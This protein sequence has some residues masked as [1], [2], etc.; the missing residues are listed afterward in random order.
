MLPCPNLEFLEF[1]G[2]ATG[3]PPSFVSELVKLRTFRFTECS[4]LVS[5]R[6]GRLIDFAALHTLP[7][8]AHVQFYHSACED[9]LPIGDAQSQPSCRQ[10]SIGSRT[11]TLCSA[12]TNRNAD[13]DPLGIRRSPPLEQ[14]K[15]S[16]VIWPNLQSVVLDSICAKDV[17]WLCDLLVR[18]S[19]GS[20]KMIKLSHSAKRHLTGSLMMQGEDPNVEFL[21]ASTGS[22]GEKGRRWIRTV[23][24]DGLWQVDVV[25]PFQW[26][27]F[28]SSIHTISRSLR[29][30]PLPHSGNVDRSRVILERI[31][32]WRTISRFERSK[33]RIYQATYP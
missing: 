1:R 5:S 21:L 12:E 25:F 13:R 26:L 32:G 15:P 9:I 4:I 19:E 24:R 31:N 14:P 30:V 10:L 27:G 28:P 33:A 29:G 11:V 16:S 17:L 23:A 3:I 7:A 2:P 18:D 8:V 20:V 22:V 6:S